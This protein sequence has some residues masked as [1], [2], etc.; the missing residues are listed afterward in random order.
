MRM[1]INYIDLVCSNFVAGQ[2]EEGTKLQVELGP[3]LEPNP[4]VFSFDTTGWKVFFAMLLVLTMGFVVFQMKRYYKNAYRRSAI[5]RLLVLENKF[6]MLQNQ[7]FVNACNML[8]KQLAISVYG[9]F[10]VGTLYG[11]KWAVFL[12]NKSDK[13]DFTSLDV[14]FYR[15]AVTNDPILTA[16][17]KAIAIETKKWIL[18]HAR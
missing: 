13:T 8:L 2:V 5:N 10:N 15:A 9:R 6:T 16:Q 7:E 4:V 14:L 17:R 18:T 1:L 12:D 11:R 3:L